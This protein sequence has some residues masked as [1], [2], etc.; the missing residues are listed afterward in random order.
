MTDDLTSREALLRSIREPS[1]AMLNAAAETP[2]MKAA[3]AAMIMHQA[4][5]YG[6]SEGAFDAG[7]PLLQ[8]WHAMIDVALR[9]AR[10]D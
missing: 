6:F 10:N 8:A 4:R 2:G 1:E 5:G 3:S 7:S 9:E